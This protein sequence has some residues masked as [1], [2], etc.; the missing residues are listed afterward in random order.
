[1][2]ENYMQIFLLLK[3]STEKAT[4]GFELLKKGYGDMTS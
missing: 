3:R 2:R 4:H 1:M